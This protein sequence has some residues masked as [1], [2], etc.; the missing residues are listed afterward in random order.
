MLVTLERGAYDSVIT[1]SLA[2][3]IANSTDIAS[4][5]DLDAAE[6]PEQ[7]ARLIA[8]ATKRAIALLPANDRVANG[9]QLTNQV[10]TTIGSLVTKAN[11]DDEQV[12]ANPKPQLLTSVSSPTPTGGR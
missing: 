2:E 1:A 10:L 12:V 9:A 3:A 11:T 5:H 7:F 4:L 8:D 6:A